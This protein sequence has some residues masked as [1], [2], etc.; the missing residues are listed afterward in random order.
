MDKESI[1]QY[2]Q[3]GKIAG[4]AREYG[5]SLMKADSKI[6]DVLDSIEKFIQDKGAGIAFPAQI[7]LNKVA[8]HACSDLG[9]ETVLKESDVAKLD[10]GAHINGFIGDTAT[11]VNLDG[12]YK[13]LVAASRAALNAASEMMVVGTKTGEIGATI[14]ETISGLGF[15]PVRNLSGHGLGQYQIHTDPSIPN[16]K[17]DT[18]IELKEGMTVACEP[19]AT[20]G[21]GMIAEGGT[22][23]V[24]SPLDSPARVRSPIARELLKKIN[25]YNG[26]PFA[27]RWLEKEFGVGKTRLGLKELERAGL[28]HG[29]PPLREVGS[30]MVSQTEHSFLITDGKPIITTKLDDD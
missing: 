16:I 20:D 24:F 26:L 19:F 11:T 17:L 7:S 6:K 1:E 12:K 15:Q 10:V 8:A 30:G 25:S 28:V 5:V 9:D 27:S 13:E 23:T 4:Q 18:K 2:K 14:Q 3:A 29:H 21:K 22:A